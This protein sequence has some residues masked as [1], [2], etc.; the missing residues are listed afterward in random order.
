MSLGSFQPWD[1]LAGDR[2]P[3]VDGVSQLEDHTRLATHAIVSFRVLALGSLRS[4]D[5]AVEHVHVHL[6]KT[7][8]RIRGIPIYPMP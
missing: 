3:V 6:L 1:E 4:I 7:T 5:G 2:G 8:V